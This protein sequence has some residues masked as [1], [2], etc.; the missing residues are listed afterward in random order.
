MG[1]H[2]QWNGVGTRCPQRTCSISGN[3]N[4]SKSG[5]ESFEVVYCTVYTNMVTRRLR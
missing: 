4:H 1:S 3:A 2:F 5:T